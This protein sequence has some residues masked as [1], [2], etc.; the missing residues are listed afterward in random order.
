MNENL[1]LDWWPV[2]A[3]IVAYLVG[4]LVWGLRLEGIAKMNKQAIEHTNDRVDQI[5]NNID[6]RLT[7]VDSSLKSIDSKL[8]RIVWSMP[9][10]LKE[11]PT[12]NDE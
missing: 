6:K 1:I 8:E 2:V 3:T 7:L 5:H 10:Q 12:R 9:S 4:L 11:V